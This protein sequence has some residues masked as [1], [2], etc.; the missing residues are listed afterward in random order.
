MLRKACYY[1][2]NL[3]ENDFLMIVTLRN[4]I[5]QFATHYNKEKI[6]QALY[7]YQPCVIFCRLIKINIISDHRPGV[8]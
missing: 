1:S 5:N 6:R 7:I 4:K 2:Y 8:H 3:Y